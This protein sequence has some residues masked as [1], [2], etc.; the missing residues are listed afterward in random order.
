MLRRTIAFIRVLSDG[1]STPPLGTPTGK[2][3]SEPHR[4][5]QDKELKA[6]AFEAMKQLAGQTA[7]LDTTP[8]VEIADENSNVFGK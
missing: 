2:L 6:R 3:I 1:K 5:F 8:I 7:R 4:F